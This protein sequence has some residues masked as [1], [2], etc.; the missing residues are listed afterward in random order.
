M[1]GDDLSLE[2]DAAP[3]GH[4]WLSGSDNAND[5]TGQDRNSPRLKVI[6][7]ELKKDFYFISIDLL[8]KDVLVFSLFRK[9]RFE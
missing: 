7:F 4:V 8:V 3:W 5:W 1:K 6:K 2:S 9:S